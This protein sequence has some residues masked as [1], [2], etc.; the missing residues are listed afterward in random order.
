MVER[1]AHVGIAV[2]SIEEARKL[3]ETLGLEVEAVEEVPAEGVRVALIPCGDSS[4]AMH[5]QS[6]RTAALATQ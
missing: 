3:Y 5:W 1:I 4:A 2:A 6:M